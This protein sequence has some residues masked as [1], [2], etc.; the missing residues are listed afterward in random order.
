MKNIRVNIW[1]VFVL[2]LFHAFA[3]YGCSATRPSQE[4][5]ARF[6]KGLYEMNFYN[7]GGLGHWRHFMVSIVRDDSVEYVVSSVFPLDTTFF[8]LK[9]INPC[10]YQHIFKHSSPDDSITRALLAKGS[11]IRII[12]T[13]DDFY[14]EKRGTV[15]DTVWLKAR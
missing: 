6:R 12:S 14:I 8:R 9:W 7:P 15:K 13:H 3:N 10:Q 11:L 5:C 1:L 4:D 2:I